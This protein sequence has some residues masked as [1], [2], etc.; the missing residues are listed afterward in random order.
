[1]IYLPIIGAFLEGAGMTIEKIILKKRS[2][3]YK[4]YTVFGFLAIVIATLP[5]S[6]FFWRVSPEAYL[7]KN[8][9]VFFLVIFFS[10][11]ANLLTFVALKRENLSVIEPIRLMQPLLTILFAFIMSFFFEIYYNERNYSILLLGFIASITLVVSHIKKHHLVFDKYIIAALLGSLF[12]AVELVLSKFI[13][14]YYNGFTF[15][16]L[17]CSVIFIITLL[18]FR[19]K[20]KTDKKTGLFILLTG[21]IWV[22]YRVI[23]YYGYEV[24]GIV[25]TTILFILTP[26][27]IYVFAKIFLKEKLTLR[28]IISSIVILVCVVLAIIIESV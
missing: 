11:I 20:L 13:L 5:L 14:S 22:I 1:M 23:L 6:F 12:F 28:N 17:R 19:P 21:I 25:F 4:N 15:Y 16:F 9:F 7:F 2:L 27:F 8:L 24:Y 10:I 26:I 3:N 18:I